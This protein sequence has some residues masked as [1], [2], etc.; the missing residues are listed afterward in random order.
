LR[1]SFTDLGLGS[2]EL[3]PT[4]GVRLDLADGR[5]V[6]VRPSGTEPKVKCY[7]QATGDSAATAKSLLAELDAAMRGVLA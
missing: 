2:A 7:L 1:V 5:R 4:D 3:P 6:I